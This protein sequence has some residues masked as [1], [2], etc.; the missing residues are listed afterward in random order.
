MADEHPN[1]VRCFAME[2]DAEFVYLALERCKQS[3]NDLLGGS[4]LGAQNLFL[5]SERQ[6]TEFC[7]QASILYCSADGKG[8]LPSL[9]RYGSLALSAEVSLGLVLSVSQTLTL[10]GLPTIELPGVSS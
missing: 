10:V 8:L 6:V 1:I 2:E 4:N 5:D 3:L 7:R 9:K